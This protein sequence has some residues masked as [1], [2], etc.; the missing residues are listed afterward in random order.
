MLVFLWCSL[1]FVGAVIGVIS[2]TTFRGRIAGLAISCAGIV[3]L[4]EPWTWRA[5]QKSRDKSCFTEID[6]LDSAISN[7]RWAEIE[8]RPD[9]EAVRKAEALRR[10]LQNYLDRCVDNAATCSSILE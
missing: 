1:G 3:M 10:E 9:V 7:L 8:G 4:V 2:A 6:R 5:P